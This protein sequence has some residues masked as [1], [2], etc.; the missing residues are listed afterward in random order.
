MNQSEELGGLIEQKKFRGLIEP[1]TGARL[2]LKKKARQAN[3]TRLINE[4]EIS[5]MNLQYAGYFH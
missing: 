4:L 5:A 1:N 2:F 3:L